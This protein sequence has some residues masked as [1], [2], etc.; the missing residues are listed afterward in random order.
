MLTKITIDRLQEDIEWA[1]LQVE[2]GNVYSI[3]WAKKFAEDVQMLLDIL[4]D[5]HESKKG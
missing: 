5:L 3:T 4:E 2:K 1:K